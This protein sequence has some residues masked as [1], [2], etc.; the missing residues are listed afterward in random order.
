MWEVITTDVFDQWLFAQNQGLRED[1]LA[2]M[3]ILEEFGPHLGRPY[4]D[5][6]HGSIFPN[7]KELRIQHE[8][9]P[10]R[11]FLLSIHCAA[12]SYFALA[13]KQA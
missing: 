13:I 6:L 11:A 12:P 1:V 3:H 8:G 4:V 2:A 9:N 10:V 5:T 7:L